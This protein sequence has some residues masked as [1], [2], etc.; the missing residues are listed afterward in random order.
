MADGLKG[1]AFVLACVSIMLMLYTTQLPQYGD[2]AIGTV[3]VFGAAV[4][5]YILT[6]VVAIPLVF[7]S[8]ATR[9][10]VVEVI[11]LSFAITV[12]VV[13]GAL[14]VLWSEALI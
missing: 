4:V 10:P 5:S 3:M 6:L 1:G 14:V 2:G 9:E 11:W 7:R 8:I 13:V 12:P